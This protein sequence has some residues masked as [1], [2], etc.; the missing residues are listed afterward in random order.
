MSVCLSLSVSMSVCLSVSASLCQSV[1]LF[2]SPCLYVCLSLHLCASLS[3]RP[4]VCMSVCSCYHDC[5]HGS[6]SG[7][8]LYQCMCDVGW[9]SADC[10]RDCGCHNHS[11]CQRGVGQCDECRNFTAGAACDRCVRG[12]YG[13]ATDPAVGQSPLTLRSILSFSFYRAILCIRG[14]SHGPVSMS[15]SV[16]HKSVFY[17]NG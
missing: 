11:T 6:C 2:L 1:C 4:S 12:S 13:S 9:T 3:V 8:P 17:Q 10:S 7:P 15:V 5:V 16:C 14:T